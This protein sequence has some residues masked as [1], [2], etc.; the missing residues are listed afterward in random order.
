LFKQK[1]GSSEPALRLTDEMCGVGPAWSPDGAWIACSMSTAGMALAPASGGPPKRLGQGY[2]PWAVWSRD[3]EL[4]YVV[5]VNGDLRELGALRWRT[6]TFQPLNRLPPNLVMFER[7]MHGG[8]IS[9][10][11]DGRSLVATAE[12]TTGDIWILD[13]LR[14]PRPSWK[15]MLGVN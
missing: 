8:R 9:L 11:Y 15:R 7:D 10:S 6:G 5:R 4:L 14:P 3:G 12:R 1:V 13:G 2:G